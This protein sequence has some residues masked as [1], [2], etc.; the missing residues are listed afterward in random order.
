MIRARW[1]A[2][3]DE[4]AVEKFWLPCHCED[5]E[6][7]DCE[8]NG[9]CDDSNPEIGPHA[10]EIPGN[11]ID[12]NCEGGDA[13]LD[14][15]EDD[16]ANPPPEVILSPSDLASDTACDPAYETPEGRFAPPNTT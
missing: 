4:D 7:T 3:D 1:E 6:P 12:D 8:V 2:G 14:S 13:P 10:K 15:L 9:D 16:A 5:A 11:G